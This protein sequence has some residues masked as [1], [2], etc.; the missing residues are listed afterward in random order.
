MTFNP[1]YPQPMYPQPGGYGQP[2]GQMPYPQAPGKSIGLGK[3]YGKGHGQ[4][5]HMPGY[6]HGQM[7]HMPGYGHGMQHYPGQMYGPGFGQMPGG[8]QSGYPYPQGGMGQQYPWFSQG[9]FRDNKSK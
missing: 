1:H 3:G 7:P 8:F 6:G 9:T 4:M 5:P 2:Y